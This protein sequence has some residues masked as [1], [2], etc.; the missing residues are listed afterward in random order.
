MMSMQTEPSSFTFLLLSFALLGSR[1]G[2][3]DCCGVL[4]LGSGHKPLDEEQVYLC[5]VSVV[6]EFMR[7]NRI[8]RRDFVQSE[9]PSAKKTLHE[10]RDTNLFEKADKLVHNTRRSCFRTSSVSVDNLLNVFM[11]SQQH[12]NENSTGKGKCTYV[13]IQ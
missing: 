4:F 11:M 9:T 1:K 8:R 10:E 6:L 2:G 5:S 3:S 13:N 12:S 7:F